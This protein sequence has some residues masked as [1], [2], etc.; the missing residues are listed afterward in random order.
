MKPR[1]RIKSSVH[2]VA[3]SWSLCIVLSLLVFLP[4]AGADSLKKVIEQDSLMRVTQEFSG[5][6]M[7]P[8]KVQ[9]DPSELNTFWPL[10]SSDLVTAKVVAEPLE[11]GA[12]ITL[13][14][15]GTSPGWTFSGNTATKQVRADGKKASDFDGFLPGPNGA[16]IPY[17]MINGYCFQATYRHANGSTEIKEF[18]ARNGI[19]YMPYHLAEPLWQPLR[20]QFQFVCYRL[21]SGSNG[22][23]FT[24]V[25]G[26]KVYRI[27]TGKS[28]LYY[29]QAGEGTDK[30]GN[31]TFLINGKEN[32]N[33]LFDTQ[34]MYKETYSLRI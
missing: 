26:A 31:G 5:P 17:M 2:P 19:V 29:Q 9:P 20:H 33:I 7:R 27:D 12:S 22:F 14:P 23:V 32:E 18:C 4:V 16:V 6:E 10:F 24:P 25:P 21:D 8:G 13:A 30:D 3:V 28:K 11:A 15:M 1:E 34:G